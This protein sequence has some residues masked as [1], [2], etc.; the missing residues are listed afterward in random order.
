[1]DFDD[2]VKAGDFDLAIALCTKEL[3]PSKKPDTYL[4]RADLYCAEG[5]W[6]KA[7]EDCSAVLASEPSNKTP[8]AVKANQI[9]AFA[10]LNKGEFFHLLKDDGKSIK[11][12][13]LN[14]ELS[15]LIYASYGKNTEALGEYQKALG[16]DP[17]SFY[18]RPLLLREYQ[19]LHKKLISSAG[20]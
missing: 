7:I 5:E 17:A 16:T 2:A 1:M 11:I 14:S 12:P 9:R 13:D 15:A 3:Y 18:E 10:Y 8:N 4:K 19:R 20:A 6:D